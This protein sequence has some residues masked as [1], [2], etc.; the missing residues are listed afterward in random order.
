[1]VDEGSW[2]SSEIG[3]VSTFRSVARGAAREVLADDLM[4][5]ATR[6]QSTAGVSYANG[7][8]DSAVDTMRWFKKG[9]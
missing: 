1:M 9:T 7:L 5:G 6:Y 2:F 3:S 8:K 4:S